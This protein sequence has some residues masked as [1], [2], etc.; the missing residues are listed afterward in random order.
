MGWFAAKFLGIGRWVWVL[1]AIALVLGAYVWLTKAEEADDKAN[2]EIGASVQ[3]EG[4]L[5][6]TLERVEKADEVRETF[7]AD[8]QRVY[9][10]CLRS[11][12]TPANCERFLPDRQDPDD[13]PVAP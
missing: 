11:A 10:E 9:D 1:I 7:S 5:R 2:Q 6:E 13:R 3:R 4:D 12:R 8:D